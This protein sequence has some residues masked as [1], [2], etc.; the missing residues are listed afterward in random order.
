[1]VRQTLGFLRSVPSCL[2]RMLKSSGGRSSPKVSGLGQ[3]SALDLRGHLEVT[4]PAPTIGWAWLGSPRS[5][6][7]LLPQSP[8]A[9][10]GGA[11]RVQVQGS[12][13][14]KAPRSH[15]QQMSAD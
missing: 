3:V 6:C 5:P 8:G 15:K 4:V 9:Q 10:L 7:L 1:M 11:R 14:A 12:R 13:A 2:L